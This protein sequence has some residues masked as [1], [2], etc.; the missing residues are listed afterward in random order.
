M[1]MLVNPEV[2]N[3]IVLAVGILLIGVSGYSLHNLIFRYHILT[4]KLLADLG[5]IR[6][7]AFILVYFSA[8][9]CAV[10][11]TVQRPAIER[12]KG[13]LGDS[14]QVFEIDITKEP[15]LALRW[16]V[17]SVP[18]TFLI[19]PRGELHHANYDVAPAENL[20]IQLHS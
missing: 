12:L 2:L 10:C 8:P 6:S 13:I 19:N 7:G 14:L 11:K 17:L 16:G 4:R 20:L 5:P 3:R 18:A 1:S 9:T 15:E